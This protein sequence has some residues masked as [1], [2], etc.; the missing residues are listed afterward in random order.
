MPRKDVCADQLR[1]GNQTEVRQGQ[2]RQN[3]GQCPT[4]TTRL[5]PSS[6]LDST[7]LSQLA[8]F[9]SDLKGVNL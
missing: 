7:S 9:I 1:L 5:L 3:P 2:T 6:V 8:P 4:G